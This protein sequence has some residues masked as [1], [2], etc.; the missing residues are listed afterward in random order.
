LATGSIPTVFT[1]LPQL[2]FQRQWELIRDYVLAGGTPEAHLAMLARA[3]FPAAEV[4]AARQRYQQSW[5]TTLDWL[6]ASV[7]LDAYFAQAEDESVRGVLAL[8]DG[9]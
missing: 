2:A 8:V 6:Q 1:H 3:E 4:Q 5:Q 7:E 9:F